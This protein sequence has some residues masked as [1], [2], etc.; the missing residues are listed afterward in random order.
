[1]KL[2]YKDYILV[3]I[4]GILF[5]GYVLPIPAMHMD[6]PEYMAYLGLSLAIIGV[7]IIILAMLQL[8]TNLSPFP[9]PISNGTLIQ[10]GLYKYIRHPIYSGILFAGIGYAIYAASG[11]KILIT[12]LLLLLFIIKSNYEEKKLIAAFDAYPIYKK[13]TGRFFPKLF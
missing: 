11:S 2:H 13:K 12:F 3:G 7:L 1:M 8:N 6:I 9:T 10:H 4:Q 5:I